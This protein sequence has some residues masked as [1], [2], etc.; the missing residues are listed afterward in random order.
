MRRFSTLSEALNAIIN[1][2]TEMPHINPLFMEQ[3]DVTQAINESLSLISHCEKKLNIDQI[4]IKSVFSYLFLSRDL[5]V[6]L[7]SDKIGKN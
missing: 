7:Q 2:N 1:G 3:T 5:P 4:M 6:C